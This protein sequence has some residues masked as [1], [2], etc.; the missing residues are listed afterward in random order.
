MAQDHMAQ[1]HTPKNRRK[2]SLAWRVRGRFGAQDTCHR[3]DE[4]RRVNEFKQ[5][6]TGAVTVD[7]VVLTAAIVGLGIAVILSV[8]QGTGELAGTIEDTLSAAQVVSIFQT[9]GGAR[10]SSGSGTSTN[11]TGGTP[12]AGSP[13]GG[14]SGNTTPAEQ[15]PTSDPDRGQRTSGGG[16]G[17]QQNHDD[18]DPDSL[19]N[20]P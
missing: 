19:L 13:S 16:G 2:S 15:N 10:T 14:T 20:N 1:D 3:S 8:R 18:I 17:G 12:T 6:E 11:S 9:S 7:W 4:V 5:D